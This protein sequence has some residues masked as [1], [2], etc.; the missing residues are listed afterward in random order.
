LGKKLKKAPDSDSRRKGKPKGKSSSQKFGKPVH[1][2]KGKTKSG[3][4]SNKNS[5]C[6][7]AAVENLES[8]RQE[9]QLLVQQLIQASSVIREMEEKVYN[10]SRKQT[11]GKVM[12]AGLLH[13]LRNPLAVIS[14]CAQSCLEEQEEDAPIREKLQMIME[15]VKKAN[16]LSKIFLD[17]TRTSVLDYRPV[18]I[19]KTLLVMWKMSELQSAPSKVK[20]A[21]D[22]D[23]ALPEITGSQENLERVF[24]NLFMNAIHAVSGKGQVSIKTR[25]LSLEKRVEIKITDNGPG[26]PEEQRKRIFDPFYTTKEQGTGL[27][28][29]ISQ[30][31]VLQH[32]GEIRIDSEVGQGT[33]VSIKLPVMQDDPPARINGGAP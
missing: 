25:F 26:I 22:L 27:G 2:R 16:D 12:V 8:P 32:G 18:N 15:N 5:G 3:D 17:H 24:L 13:D 6:S 29:N 10:E 4:N 21:A 1:S 31:L 28:L 9:N 7:G 19:N 14:S 20:F 11:V 30:S 33:T 23:K